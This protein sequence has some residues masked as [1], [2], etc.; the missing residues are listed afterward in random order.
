M[1]DIATKPTLTPGS[2]DAATTYALLEY[3]GV[4][5]KMTVADLAALAGIGPQGR[6]VTGVEY[7]DEGANT[8][9]LRFTLTDPADQSTQT[10]TLSGIPTADVSGAEA[11]TRVRGGL[12]LARALLQQ[13]AA[14]FWAGDSY[15]N[16]GTDRVPLQAANLWAAGGHTPPLR[17]LYL[18]NAEGDGTRNWGGF[19]LY[20]GG[21]GHKL[22]SSADGYAA[23]GG[24]EHVGLPSWTNEIHVT[25]SLTLSTDGRLCYFRFETEGTAAAGA[26]ALVA[27]ADAGQP[28]EARV[29]AYAPHTAGALLD[30]V[31]ALRDRV[32]GGANVATVNPAQGTGLPGG[33]PA[34]GTFYRFPDVE[35]DNTAGAPAWYGALLALDGNAAG[36]APDLDQYLHLAGCLVHRPDRATGPAHL[37]LGEA[38]WSYDGWSRDE[39]PAGADDKSFRDG[40]LRTWAEAVRLDANQPA[41]VV[42]HLNNEQS[43][44]AGSVADR[45]Q[46]FRPLVARVRERWARLLTEAGYGQV[47]VVFVHGQGQG[48]VNA[49]NNE[50]LLQA[51]RQESELH[52]GCG[53]VSLWADNEN[54][55]LNGSPAAVDYLGRV[56]E[57]AL[58]AGGGD[59]LD[60]AEVHPA[61]D[62]AAAFWARRLAAH[63]FPS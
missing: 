49:D 18:T 59:L 21:A 54:L 16:T 34:P 60:E 26:G 8:F 20:A 13:N 40:D 7:L 10:V 63:L 51:I 39:D 27:P 6:G 22:L 52:A 24:A 56:G 1:G 41:V 15:V 5:W 53:Y 46:H 55:T 37:M 25:A 2:V 48:S 4:F 47:A 3:S 30:D 58:A 28:V 19:Y 50:A 38:S 33:V 42:V 32:S 31:V 9:G 45:V 29:V 61:D 57:A 17:A 44:V 36:A 62:D 35:L 12:E 23:V 14:V 11:P 43:P